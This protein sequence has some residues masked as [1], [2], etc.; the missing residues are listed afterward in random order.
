MH[1]AESTWETGRPDETWDEKSKAAYE[2]VK[3]KILAELPQEPNWLDQ[4]TVPMD[5]LM[6]ELERLHA[7]AE[8]AEDSK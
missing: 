1:V 2:A 8:T 3:A 5:E 4:P 6:E 7:E